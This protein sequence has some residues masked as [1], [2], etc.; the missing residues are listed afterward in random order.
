MDVY[1]CTQ[2]VDFLNQQ[3]A[4]CLARPRNSINVFTRRLGGA[5]GNKI[6]R[7]AQTATICA[8]CAHKVGRPVRLC[9]DM[10]TGMHMFRGRLPYLL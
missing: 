2:C 6:V 10:E 1:C 5:F 8:L 9:L 3:V 4:S 7:S